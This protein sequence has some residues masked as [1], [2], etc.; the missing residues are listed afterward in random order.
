MLRP[1]RPVARAAIHGHHGR[2]R[3]G[4]RSRAARLLSHTS[5]DRLCRRSADEEWLTARPIGPEPRRAWWTSIGSPSTYFSTTTR[6]R[7]LEVR[8]SFDVTL[9]IPYDPGTFSFKSEVCPP[10]EG[11]DVTEDDGD[12]LGPGSLVY[13]R[14]VEHAVGSLVLKLQDE[15]LQAER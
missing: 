3:P 9:R 13:R 15:L 4:Q 10:R 1:E 7:Y 6:R 2:A 5:G 14:M 11:F 12:P 8:L